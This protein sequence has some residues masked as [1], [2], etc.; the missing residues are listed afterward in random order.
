[1]SARTLSPPLSLGSASDVLVPLRC[2][3][4]GPTVRF[5]ED[6]SGPYWHLP[7]VPYA[8]VD[9]TDNATVWVE[10]ARVT[11]EFKL[12]CRLATDGEP[13]TQEVMFNQGVCVCVCVCARARVYSQPATAASCVYA[14]YKQHSL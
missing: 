4:G 2:I 1:M 10:A 14:Y 9:S 11:E 13:A 6:V 8:T 5:A 12:E 3:V 7:N